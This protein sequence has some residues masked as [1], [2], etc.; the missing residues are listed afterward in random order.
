MISTRL[1]NGATGMRMVPK[2]APKAYRS[3]ED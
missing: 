1:P 2:M 3:F